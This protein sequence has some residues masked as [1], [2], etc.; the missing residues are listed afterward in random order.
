MRVLLLHAN[1]HQSVPVSPY[2]LDTLAQTLRARKS[3]AETL[4]VNPFLESVD[5]RAH[6][7][8]VLGEFE[9]DLIGLSIRNIDNAIVAV[10]EDEPSDGSPID[11]VGYAPAIRDLVGVI[12]E[13][14]EDV[15]CVAGGS[16]FTSCPAEFLGYLGLDFGFTGPAEEAFAALVTALDGP[17]RPGRAQA[18]AVIERLPGAVH[19]DGSGFRVV[20]S[21][22]A[23]GEE[24]AYPPRLAPEYQLLYRLRGIPVAV[25]TKSGCPLRC[26]YCTD[27]IN[28]RRI[29]QRPV[30]NVIGE[31]RHHVEEHGLTFFH[32][33]DPELNLPYEDHLLRVCAALKDS[34]LAERIRWRGYFNVIPFSDALVD[35]VLDA[36]CRAPSFAVDSFH[37][38]GLRGHQKSFREHQVHDVLGRFLARGPD[39][40]PEICLLFGQP[41]ETRERIDAN[42]RWML[43]YADRGAQISYSCGLRV[44]PN[45]PLART[46]LEPRHLY[47]PPGREVSDRL[48]PSD[49]LEPVVYCEP[50]PPRELARYVAER[51][52]GH[53]NIG[54]FADWPWPEARHYEALRHFN[55]GVHRMAHGRFA[56][57]AGHLRQ[58]LARHE[59]LSPARTA[60]GV[61]ENIA[62]QAI[63]P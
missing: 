34:G 25:R 27:P 12:R 59:G 18:A 46:R 40:R 42:I 32:I 35:A 55:V 53:P 52:G 11:V 8:E 57:A 61:V 13:W 30:A 36:G 44:Y 24:A 26:A 16:G 23:L 45:T 43:H 2:G 21:A 1:P 10:S 20:P 54:V 50:L 62:A 28:T 63:N 29:G 51:V 5:T 19:R 31:I 58:A 14:N 17:R 33:A 41:G 56:E 49:L 9:P 6:L 15:V 7:L 3:P 37:E 22:G 4:I 39:V 38:D 48:N 60:L 47:V